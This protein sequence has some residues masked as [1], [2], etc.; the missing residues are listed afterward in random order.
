MLIKDLSVAKELDSKEM[1]SVHGGSNFAITK[2]G[3]VTNAANS[4]GFASPVTQVGITGPA[5]TTQLNNPIN[6]LGR[7]FVL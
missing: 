2:S 6:V 1:A 3:D 7:Q 4:S 5:I